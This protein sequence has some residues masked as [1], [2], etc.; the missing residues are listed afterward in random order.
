MTRPVLSFCAWVLLAAFAWETVEHYLETVS[1]P[2]IVHWFQG[3]EFW[4]NRCIADP[5]LVLAGA[6]LFWWRGSRAAATAAR[7]FTAAWLALHICVLPDSMALQRLF[8]DLGV[9]F[10]RKSGA[11]FDV[12]SFDHLVSGVSLGALVAPHFKDDHAL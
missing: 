4:G 11:W 1:P 6:L 2:A 8:P 9:L 3:V 10:G 5:A 7:V 12:W